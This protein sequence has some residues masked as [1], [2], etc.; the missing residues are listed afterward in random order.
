[1]MYDIRTST[2]VVRSA[3]IGRRIP[4]AMMYDITVANA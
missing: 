2:T 3:V 1:M 4:L